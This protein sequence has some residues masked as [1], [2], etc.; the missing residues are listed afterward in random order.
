MR[1]RP[2][3]DHGEQW[4]PDCRVGAAVSFVAESLSRR[5][6]GAMLVVEELSIKQILN[7]FAIMFDA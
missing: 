7:L 5:E 2:E 1:Q 6:V 3:R 4:E